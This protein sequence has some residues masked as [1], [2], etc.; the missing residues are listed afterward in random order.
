MK[1]ITI[2]GLRAKIS[3]P[4]TPLVVLSVSSEEVDFMPTFTLII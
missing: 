2:V 3:I 1:P 4:A